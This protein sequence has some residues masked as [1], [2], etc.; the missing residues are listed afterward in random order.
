MCQTIARPLE[1]SNGAADQVQ[2]E[3]IHKTARTN[4]L[5]CGPIPGQNEMHSSNKDTKK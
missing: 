4:I 3:N 2:T 5:I 1:S